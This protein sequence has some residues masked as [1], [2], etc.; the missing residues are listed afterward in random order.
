MK[1]RMGFI[2]SRPFLAREKISMETDSRC[3]MP[4]YIS[5]PSIFIIGIMT[6]VTK[7]RP[8]AMNSRRTPRFVLSCDRREDM[9]DM[10]IKSAA[11]NGSTGMKKLSSFVPVLMPKNSDM[12]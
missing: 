3:S 6:A 9:P 1:P 11:K 10:T 12:E 4:K 7:V 2:L 5:A 8:S